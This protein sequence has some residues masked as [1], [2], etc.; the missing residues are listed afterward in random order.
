MR[1]SGRGKAAGRR[2]RDVAGDTDGARTACCQQPTRGACKRTGA[3]AR[4][5]E[6]V[7]PRG[8]APWRRWRPASSL[9]MA[10]ELLRAPRASVQMA[11]T[12]PQGHRRCRI[13]EVYRLP[14]GPAPPCTKFCA[15]HRMASRG[16]SQ[17]AQWLWCTFTSRAAAAGSPCGCWAPRSLG[18]CVLAVL[19]HGLW[20]V[21]RR[22]GAVWLNPCLG[23]CGRLQDVWKDANPCGCAAV[24]GHHRAGCRA[25]GH[26]GARQGRG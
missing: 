4:A 22:V 13:P 20:G 18:M 6:A 12:C 9:P 5:Q 3:Y 25:R 14:S 8:I 10:S 19:Y 24:G 17:G 21:S 1:T 23:V 7:L 26:E 11:R 15:S 16:P 2:W